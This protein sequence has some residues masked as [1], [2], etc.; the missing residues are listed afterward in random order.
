MTS[1]VITRDVPVL[2]SLA[3][4]FPGARLAGLVCNTTTRYGEN[5]RDI[6]RFWMDYLD[7][8]SMK[9]LHGETFVKDHTEY[10]ICFPRDN[11]TGT[12]EYFLGV[13]VKE[14]HDVPPGYV[15]RELPPGVYRVFSSAPS[16]TPDFPGA[17]F[18][19]W[20]YIFG[21][22][23]PQSGCAIDGRFPQFERYDER[24]FNYTGKVCEIYIP[25]RGTP[26]GNYSPNTTA[27][28]V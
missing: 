2:Q 7:S 28:K 25:L 16:D 9:N 24:V 20:A 13:A 23:L 8:G 18:N 11:W 19:T 1:E 17:I 10:G 12:T 6:P 22:W 14:G 5:Y 21:E 26:A 15:I 4:E 3:V 27:V